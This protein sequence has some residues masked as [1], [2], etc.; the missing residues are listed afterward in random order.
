MTNKKS[1]FND[2]E[3][4]IKIIVDYMRENDLQNLDGG[5]RKENNHFENIAKLYDEKLFLPSKA[6]NL[7]VMWRRNDKNLR[8]KVEEILKN[9]NE[10]MQVISIDWDNW[11][12]FEACISQNN[13]PKFLASSNVFFQNLF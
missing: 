3:K 2:I 11:K 9:S 1:N 13:R 4:L 6:L 7:Y 5:Y 12:T 10:E 8:N